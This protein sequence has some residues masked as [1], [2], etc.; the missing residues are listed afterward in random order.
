MA[1]STREKTQCPTDQVGKM[2]KQ[3]QMTEVPGS[4]EG[5]SVSA[6]AGLLTSKAGKERDDFFWPS[7]NTYF[8]TWQNVQNLS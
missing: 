4:S 2:N 5:T 6:S 3:V 7:A 8:T 1:S